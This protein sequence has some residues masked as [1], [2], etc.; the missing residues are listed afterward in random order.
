[1]KYLLFL[2]CLIF[3]GCVYFNERGVS[4]KYYN[5]CKEYYDATGTYHK[6]CDKN[7]INYKDVKDAS[8]KIFD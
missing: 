3:S 6:E 5:D 8:T 2:F 7:L 1:M 4:A